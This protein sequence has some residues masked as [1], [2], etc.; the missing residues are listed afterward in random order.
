M[1]LS[2]TLILRLVVAIAFVPCQFAAVLSLSQL[3]TLVAFLWNRSQPLIVSR[4]VFEDIS[5]NSKRPS[6]MS[7]RICAGLRPTISL[8][9][10]AESR[11]SCSKMVSFAH[12][13]PESLV[14]SH[15]AWSDDETNLNLSFLAYLLKIAHS[16]TG[17]HT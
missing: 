10:F 17:N 12:S 5:I 2:I 6:F 3:L 8:S 11:R 15:P 1:R 7:A 16:S 4:L 14:L 9:C 13:W